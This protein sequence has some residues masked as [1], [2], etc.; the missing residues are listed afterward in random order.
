MI[1]CQTCDSKTLLTCF[2]KYIPSSKLY[3]LYLDI[4]FTLNFTKYIYKA[5]EIRFVSWVNLI[6]IRFSIDKDVLFYFL[7]NKR[8]FCLI[9][10]N[11]NLKIKD[12]S[13]NQYL[14]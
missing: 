1:S 14:I 4:N 3:Y 5:K 13:N 10:Q 7:L 6:K 11:L 12:F 9:R 8:T 2:G